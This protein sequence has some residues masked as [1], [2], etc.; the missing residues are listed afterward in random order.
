MC[1]IVGALHRADASFNLA[2]GVSVLAHRGPNDHGVWEAP[3]VQLGFT[4]L[5]I[6]DLSAA[7]HQPMQSPDGR[8]V[9]VFNGEIYNFKEIRAELERLRYK[10]ISKTDSEVVLNAYIEWGENCV[11]RFNGMFAFAVWDKRDRAL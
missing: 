1:G 9:I 5:S 10:F 4:R 8:Y 2:R 6:L 11:H 7:G 3:G